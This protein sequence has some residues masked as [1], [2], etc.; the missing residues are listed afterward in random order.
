MG[1]F[2][3]YAILLVVSLSLTLNGNWLAIE[4]NQRQAKRVSL[5]N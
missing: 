3:E 5:W 4:N 1:K 2:L